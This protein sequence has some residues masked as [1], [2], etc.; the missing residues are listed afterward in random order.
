MWCPEC[1]FE[2]DPDNESQVVCPA[3]GADPTG[4]LRLEDDPALAAAL[5]DG[6][7]FAEAPVDLPDMLGENA[8]MEPEVDYVPDPELDLAIADAEALREAL[9]EGPVL[10][11][12]NRL[13]N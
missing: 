10:V 4:E 3:C 5:D 12:G 2:L 9:T 13:I 1:G 8:P 7:A 6:V 11:A